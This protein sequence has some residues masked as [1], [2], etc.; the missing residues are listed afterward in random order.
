MRVLLQCDVD[1]LQFD[2]PSQDWGNQAL[3]WDTLADNRLL[4]HKK[5]PAMCDNLAY[6]NAVGGHKDLEGKVPLQVCTMHIKGEGPSATFAMTLRPLKLDTSCRL[7]RKFGSSR[8]LELHIPALERWGMGDS[9][10]I[11]P[12]LAHAQHK[13]L[14]SKWAVFHN[15]DSVK[16]RDVQIDEKQDKL[17]R[18]RILLFSEKP[19]SSRDDMLNWLLN[20]EENKEEPML[21][22]FSRISLG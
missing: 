15:K 16:P 22:L 9:D 18:E 13:F 11:S 6:R 19:G 21:K 5:L 14:G 3:L 12:W 17:P 1:P 7:F 10:P 20:F 8:F 2:L 4:K